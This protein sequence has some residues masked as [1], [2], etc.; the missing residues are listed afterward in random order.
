MVDPVRPEQEP[1]AGVDQRRYQPAI[2]SAFDGVRDVEARTRDFLARLIACA[3]VVAI[4]GAGF[5]GLIAGN[6]MAVVGVW[7]VVGP[8]LGALV[9]YY[10]GPQRNDIA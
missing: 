10:F 5:Y 3:T 2:G 1:W 9:A 7:T 4:G 6:Y 8:I